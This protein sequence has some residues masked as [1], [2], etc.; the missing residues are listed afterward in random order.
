MPSETYVVTPNP[1][2]FSYPNLFTPKAAQE[3]QEPKYSLTILIPKDDKATLE[4]ISKA[5]S[6]ATEKGIADKWGGKKPAKLTLPIKDGDTPKADG[7]DRNPE[8]K[9][10]Y[11]INAS[12]NK[13]FQ[14]QVVDGTAGNQ[15]LLDG[16][17]IYAGCYG[18]VGINFYAYSASGN[19]GVSA[20]LSTVQFVKDG[21]PLGNM[22]SA[23]NDFA[24]FVEEPASGDDPLAAMLGE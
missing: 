4:A 17:K 9:G 6:K 10:H 24:G 15:I 18:R 3:G 22:A 23:A 1:V 7:T 16:R 2:R 21:E 20:G 19:N 12:S 13:D 5:V 8:Y 14:P 11:F